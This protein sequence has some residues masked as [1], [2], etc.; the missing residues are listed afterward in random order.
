MSGDQIAAAV[1]V[2]SI[3]KYDAATAHRSAFVNR[4]SELSALAEETGRV[5]Q[6]ESRVVHV[7]GRAGI[8]KTALVGAFLNDH[9][10][11]V[12]INVAG[13]EHDTGTHLGVAQALLRTLAARGGLPAEPA[14]PAAEIDPLACGMALVHHLGLAQGSDEAVVLVVDNLDWVDPTSLTALAFALRRL[15]ADRILTILIG[16]QEAQ[17]DTPLGRLITGL[18]GRSVP[19]G[20]LDTLAVR[21]IAAQFGPRAL[22]LAQAEVLRAHTDGNPLYLRAVLAELPPGR[23]I[24]AQWL[25]APGAFAAVALAPLARSPEPVRRLVAAAAVLGM[26]ARVT[27]AARLGMVSSPTEAVGE[28]PDGLIELVEGPLGWVLRFTHPLNRAAVYHD[29][30]PEERARLH[31]LAAEHTVGRPA[32]RHRVRSA[33]H[34]DLALASDLMR[35]AVEETG[36]GQLATAAEDLVAAAQVHPDAQTR[37]RL[38]LDAAD[39][40][41]WASDPFGA[42][43]L[44]STALDTSGSRWHYVHGH[45]A[46]VS[47][48]FPEARAELETA[49]EQIGPADDDLRGPMASLL[50]QIAILHSRA[51]AGA[52]WAARAVIALPR[53]HPL[54]SL[55]SAC[56]VLALWLS[57]RR[58]E[59]LTRMAGLPANPAAV[60]LEDAAQLAVRGQLRMWN[61]DLEGSRADSAR[62]LYLGRKSG[63]PLFALTAAVYLAEAEFRL[64]EWGDAVVHSDLAVSLVEDTDQLWFRAQAHGIAALVWAARG[65]WDVAEAHVVAAMAAAHQLGNEASLGYAANAAAHLAFAR[66]DWPGVV[67]AG[68]SLYGLSNRDGIFEPGVLRWRELYQEGLIAAGQL[69]EARRDVEESLDL[70]RER[71]RRSMLARISRPQAALALADGHADRARRALEEGIEHAAAVCGPFDQALLLEALGRL[72]RRQGERRQAASRLQAAIDRYGLLRAAPFLSRCGDELAACGLHPAPRVPGP[73]RLSPREQAIVRL[74][75]RGLTNRQIASELVISVKTVECHL[76]NVFAKLGVSTRTQLAAKVAEARARYEPAQATDLPPE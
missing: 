19:V 54:L 14:Y 52:D 38:V 16:R 11:L 56:L 7:S 62:A 34:P 35:A 25:P 39:L 13:S 3:V 22:S 65:G 70:A 44:L 4:A 18:G 6:G 73:M 64:G 45:L 47:G 63:V 43:A 61:D 8:G 21:E 75:V 59:A 31:A 42:A 68:L 72:L 40:R 74:T 12:G 2:G 46:T 49:W 26:E 67:A 51:S 37:H 60:T 20:G 1:A 33:L 10:D 9:P 55:S 17:P 69:A 41:L 15:N 30:S 71:D 28:V 32:L 23:A 50:A 36:H 5:S 24:D 53:G 76:V 48:R 29:L 27:D 58:D 57:G 66:Q